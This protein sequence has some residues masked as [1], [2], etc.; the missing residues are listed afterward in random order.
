MR[1]ADVSR[2][3]AESRVVAR[4]VSVRSV[5]SR[6]GWAAESRERVRSEEGNPVCFVKADGPSGAS[7]EEVTLGERVPRGFSRAVFCVRV[8]GPAAVGC[9]ES[10]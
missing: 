4:V 1:V 9:C 7:E 3:A 5:K 8:E 10:G 2:E 6:V